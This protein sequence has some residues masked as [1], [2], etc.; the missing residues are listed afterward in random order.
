MA[1]TTPMAANPVRSPSK[2]TPHPS[3]TSG[4]DLRYHRWSNVLHN[5]GGP[6]RRSFTCSVITAAQ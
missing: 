1:R 2:R 6:P 3:A 4:D 5:C